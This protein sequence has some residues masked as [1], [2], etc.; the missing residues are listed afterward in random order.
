M[1]RDVRKDGRRIVWRYG[2][3]VVH[4]IAE[5]MMMRIRSSVSL[6]SVV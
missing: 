4:R 2:D 3:R 6:Y 5:M 1:P